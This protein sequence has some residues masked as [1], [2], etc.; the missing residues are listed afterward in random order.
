MYSSSII[1]RFDIKLNIQIIEKI[2]FNL[3][4]TISISQYTFN[5]ATYYTSGYMYATPTF[6]TFKTTQICISSSSFVCKSS[7]QIFSIPN[8]H[9]EHK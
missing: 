6:K 2:N 9:L 5:P 3:R 8:L 7:K 4:Y 1:I